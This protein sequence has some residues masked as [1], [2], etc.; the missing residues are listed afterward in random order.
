MKKLFLILITGLLFSC[1]SN[2][3]TENSESV[4]P[5][6]TSMDI[7]PSSSVDNSANM[8]SSATSRSSVQIDSTSSS[9]R[10]SI[11]TR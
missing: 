8:D 9:N 2:K 3:S 5:D 6:S 4:S 10:D 7:Q 11:K 1:N